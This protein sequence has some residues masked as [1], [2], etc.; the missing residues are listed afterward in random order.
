[1]PRKKDGKNQCRSY[2]WESEYEKLSTLHVNREKMKINNSTLPTGTEMVLRRPPFSELGA[3]LA[4]N[5][6]LA[7]QNTRNITF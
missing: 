7:N 6:F 5:L 2:L 4:P 3:K 1:M